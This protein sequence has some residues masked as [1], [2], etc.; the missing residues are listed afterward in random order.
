[1]GKHNSNSKK[2][3][4]FLIIIILILVIS[5]GIFFARDIFN[6]ERNYNVET[7]NKQS[8]IEN[9]DSITQN[10]DEEIKKYPEELLW[11]SRR[12]TWYNDIRRKSRS[13][14]FS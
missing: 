11:A 4:R 10:S 7:A 6:I 12:I 2:T 8:N 13:N 1:M 3:N 9:N 14:V 5:A